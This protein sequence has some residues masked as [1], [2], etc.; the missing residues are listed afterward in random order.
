MSLALRPARTADIRALAAIHAVCF[1]RP[2]AEKEFAGLFAAGAFGFVAEIKGI[3][4]GFILC[5]I[6]ADEAEILTFAVAQE[7]RRVGIGLALLEFAMGEAASRGAA[8]LFLEVEKGNEAAITLYTKANFAA[9]GR[10]AGYYAG[11]DALVLK[12]N[13]A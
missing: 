4:A 8:S 11:N 6:A 2:W 13:L 1:P 7:C 9:I 12:R 10:R 5:R 3:P